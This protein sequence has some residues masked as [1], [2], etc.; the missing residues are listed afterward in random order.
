MASFSASAAAAAASVSPVAVEQVQ[1]GSSIQKEAGSTSS[2]STTNGAMRR[3]Q[4]IEA[5][6]S[7]EDQEAVMAAPQ[8]A[9]TFT[10]GTQ[11]K[12]ALIKPKGIQ[13][14]HSSN[15]TSPRSPNTGPS[16]VGSAPLKQLPSPTP[17]PTPTP[18]AAV[19]L[20]GSTLPLSLADIK[21][22]GLEDPQRWAYSYKWATVGIVSLM[23][24]ISPMGASIIVPGARIISFDFHLGSRT[25]AIVPV[26]TYVLGLALGPFVF[27]PAS[28]LIGRKPV[29]VYTS[30][31]FVL[32]NIATALA[33][34]YASLNILRFIAGTFGSTGPTLGS[35]S[36]G[37]MFAPRERGRAVSLY[38]LGP[39]LGPVVGNIIGGFIAQG[40]D[41]WRWLLWTLTIVSSLSP[42]KKF[43]HF[44]D[45]FA[46]GSSPAS[47]PSSLSHV[48]R[49]RTVQ[50]YS[51]RRRSD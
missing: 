20:P 32:F 5:H 36:I 27:A 15:T 8:R 41:S 9:S 19:A 42:T 44:S 45:A 18:T 7:L 34:T 4:V 1:E 11:P 30:L 51:Q 43:V 22:E 50:Y 28:E 31:L 26:S 3:H 17:T 6:I 40:S 48:S 35:G 49:K 37:D 21:L 23:G 10:A 16:F 14:S 12:S 46:I 24:F 13:R 33:P 2:P 38:G 29:Y 47:L 39:L 25:L